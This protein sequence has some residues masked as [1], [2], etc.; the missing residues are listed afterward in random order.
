M[1]LWFR[2]GMISSVDGIWLNVSTNAITLHIARPIC[3]CI[4]TF[5][6]TARRIHVIYAACSIQAGRFFIKINNAKFTCPAVSSGR[7]VGSSPERWLVIEPTCRYHWKDLFL[8]QKLS[9]D[10]PNFGQKWWCQK[11]NKDQGS[12]FQMAQ[13][14]MG[15][16]LETGK[17]N[18]EDDFVHLVWTS[19]RKFL[20]YYCD[21]ARWRSVVG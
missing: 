12:W 5:T 3:Y 14:L 21:S 19:L 7:R 1:P 17:T 10:D 11:W 16:G 8:L 13:E 4:F 6:F 18:F 9:I 15:Y 2:S 20:L